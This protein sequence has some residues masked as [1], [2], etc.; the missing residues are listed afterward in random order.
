MAENSR[1]PAKRIA[2]LIVAGLVLTCIQGAFP[3]PAASAAG[4]ASG[5]T[6]ST[7]EIDFADTFD[8]HGIS[9]EI[10]YKNGTP[11]AG[12]SGMLDPTSNY[13][14]Q[15]EGSDFVLPAWYIAIGGA[16]DVTRPINIAFQ[17]DYPSG[18]WAQ[19]SNKGAF[20]FAVY[21]G[22]DDLFTVAD[23]GWDVFGKSK[24]S[25]WGALAN[26][27][28]PYFD[29]ADA[30][31]RL[32]VRDHKAV[33]QYVSGSAG[34]FDYESKRAVMTINIGRSASQSYVALNGKKFCSLSLKQSDFKTGTVTISV[35]S[36][37]SMW[38]QTRM[39]VSQPAPVTVTYTSDAPG[40]N[41]IVSR[42]QTDDI[43]TAP[44]S[45]QN[46]EGYTFFGWYSDETCMM[47][48]DFSLPLTGD[49]KIYARYLF[50][51]IPTDP[52]GNQDLSDSLA[53]VR[54]TSQTGG[55]KDL[56]TVVIKGTTVSEPPAAA[57]RKP[58]F[59]AAWTSGAELYDFSTPVNED[60]T[61]TAKWVENELVLYHKMNDVVDKTWMYE[62]RQDEN[63]WDMENTNP[64]SIGDTFV[65]EKGNEVISQYY[66]CYS[67]DLHFFTQD[68]YTIFYLLSFGSITNLKKLDVS[69]EIVVKFL[70][71]T[72]NQDGSFGSNLT[73]H[74]FDNLY[75]A[76][77]S[78][79]DS[80]S[81]DALAVIRTQTLSGGELF[82]KFKDMLTG[83]TSEDV[84]FQ[85]EKTYTL[86]L[87]ISEDGT[88]NYLK[89]DGVDVPG[90]LEGLKQSDFTGG[91]AYLHLQSHG[92]PHLMQALV[93]QTSYLTV[94][95][96][97]NGTVQADLD[98]SPFTG[99]ELLFKQKIMLACKPD[100]GYLVK[101]AV[102]GDKIYYPDMLNNIIIYKGWED[103]RLEVE[104]VKECVLTFNSSGGSDVESQ[105]MAEGENFYK[106]SNPK[107][108]GYSFGGWYLDE[109]YTQPYD[110]KQP[111]SASLTLY[112]KWTPDAETPAPSDV[113]GNTGNGEEEPG[114]VTG[115]PVNTTLI[116]ILI[117]AGVVIV[118]GAVVIV[119]RVRKNK[120]AKTKNGEK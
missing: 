25:V 82:S 94:A 33:E 84:G 36:N 23:S 53:T 119:I 26:A 5:Y 102:I 117:A 17:M 7:G 114:D 103:E 21:D 112:A 15:N 50:G 120:P 81:M 67:P 28:V 98:D 46:I 56:E 2:L 115:K 74:L 113:P 24:M 31:H 43:I 97:T 16:L 90:A 63:G 38:L 8:K 62:Y 71:R 60:L 78:P 99:G 18:S 64:I 1:R 49:T 69:K 91:Y 10:P 45:A 86:S 106:P 30:Y 22:W 108:E 100:A 88:G 34:S 12:Y 96:F 52:S 89:V 116:I 55:F 118:A 65:D 79:H 107:K 75:S 9:P 111:A 32:I 95:P 80:T 51:T 11:V 47:P 101:Q 35:T 4:A 39:R 76:L 42:H 27:K 83:A 44:H 40:F 41:E 19:M 54:F 66:G 68:E 70:V 104:F 85:L 87:Y 110:F 77:K 37:N 105:S 48:Y 20:Y 13:V 61:L 57:F 58:G 6:D 14:I 93:A 73:F 92:A 59:S 3:P 109:A 72:I 29:G